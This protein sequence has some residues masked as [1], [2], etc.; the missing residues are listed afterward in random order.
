GDER[1]RSQRLADV[2]VQ[3]CDNALAASS[4]PVLRGH[5]PQV[6]VTIGVGELA[7]PRPAAARPTPASA[8]RSPPP[9]PA[10]WPATGR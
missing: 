6:I 9:G 5:K 7:G 1:T 3:L 2:L 8:R 4:L 10:G